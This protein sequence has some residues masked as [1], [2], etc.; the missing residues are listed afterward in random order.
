MDEDQKRVLRDFLAAYWS[1]FEDECFDND[2]SAQEIYELLG[3][4]KDV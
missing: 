4:T 3:G 2:Q 1:L